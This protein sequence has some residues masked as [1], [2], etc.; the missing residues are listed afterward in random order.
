[1]EIYQD[2]TEEIE[3]RVSDLLGKLT[4]DEKIKLLRGK[5]FWETQP[6]KRLG[7]PSFGMTDGPLGVA[8]HS[9]RRCKATRFPATIGL[10][11]SWNRDLA[12]QMGQAIA[13]EVKLVGRHQ[14]LAPGV[15]LIRT[16]LGGRNFEY[17]S[18]DP[19]LTSEIGASFV[20]G[21]QSEKVA[22]CI[23]HYATNNSETKRMTVSTEISERAL[24]EVYIKTF[25]RII[26]K[27]DPWG[28]MACYNKVNGVHGAGNKYL[29]RD[30]LRGDLGFTG[31]VVTDWFAAKGVKGGAAQCINAGLSLEMPGGLFGRVMAPR[32]VK[33]ALKKGF[34]SDGDIDRVVCPLLRTFIRVGLLDDRS[35]VKPKLKPKFVIDVPEHQRLARRIAEESMVLLKNDGPLLPVDIKSV[36]KIA[37]L[38]PNASK[39][40]GKYLHGG[41]SA[42]VPPTFIT[43][44]SGIEKYIGN[45]AKIV[46]DP[47]AA[48]V[49][50]LILGLDNGRDMIRNIIFPIEGDT[51]GR[52]RSRYQ[53]PDEQLK[54][55]YDTVEQNPNT[56]VIIVA[57]S[58]VDCHPF[59]EKAP[60][61]LNAWYPGMTGGD[62]IARVLFGD[63][64]PSG[65]LPVTYPKKL[66]DHPAHVSPERFPGRLKELKIY[67]DEGVF[68]GYRYF[69][70]EKIDPEFP[71]GF[72][73]S[74]TSFKFS[75]IQV[76]KERVSHHEEFTISVDVLNTGHFVGGEVIQV[77][78]TDDEGRVVR[79][80]KE[81]QGF[82]K[83]FVNPGE[84]KKISITLDDFAFTFYSEDKH[85]FT[86]EPGS[87][88]IHAGNASR[89]LP[90]TAKIHFDP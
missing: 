27:S 39:I 71:F 74:Y 16:P 33:K 13:R 2:K 23:K 45:K 26:E 8:S 88:T 59:V 57:G 89:N 42:V 10:A 60:A 67:Y 30:V 75:N 4:L 69:D 63:V 65:K 62:A 85:E 18:E 37:I 35:H 64:S 83:V 56:V 22:C 76:D 17:M 36:D 48:D 90:L 68:A 3:A 11:A 52:D 51:E 54:L 12:Y 29:L 72:G 73:M 9:S 15:N 21:I 50:F 32:K 24:H 7:I 82:E 78:L 79:P 44:R 80:P 5:D 34:I 31:H 47:A 46:N 66:S 53:L 86:A 28:L 84:E 38:G 61:L 87:F 77:Y 40:F 70:K 41:S 20:N 58:P 6:I 43:P 81:L 55:F 1:M 49:V 14:I 19:I 25:K